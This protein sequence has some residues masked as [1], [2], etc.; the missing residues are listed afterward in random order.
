V[1]IRKTCTTCKENSNTH[2][3]IEEE[4]FKSAASRREGRGTLTSPREV[5]G[6]GDAM[7]RGGER[8]KPHLP[9][10]KKI[11]TLTRRLYKRKRLRSKAA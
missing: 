11:M 4:G 1:N 9:D 10:E 3:R 2:W 8:A 7:K 6:L 5:E